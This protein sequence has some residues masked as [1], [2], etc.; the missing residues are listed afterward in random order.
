MMGLAASAPWP[1]PSLGTEVLGLALK[2]LILLALVLVGAATVLWIGRR[3]TRRARERLDRSDGAD[4]ASARRK[5]A[6]TFAV[7]NVVR[8]AVFTVLV[9]VVLALL[10]VDIAPILASAGFV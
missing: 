3:A 6:I 7:V 10:G 4:V 1:A 8:V 2:N 9:F 5:G